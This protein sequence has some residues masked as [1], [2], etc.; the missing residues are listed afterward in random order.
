MERGREHPY[1]PGHTIV[2]P[3]ALQEFV[4]ARLGAVFA[5][6][7][8]QVSRIIDGGSV[9]LVE[10]RYVG[11]TEAGDELDA[12]FAHVWEFG[13]THCIRFQQYSDTWQWRNVLGVAD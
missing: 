9:V 6:F 11:S 12:A 5:P 3:A 2:G 1:H 10:G 8:L 7:D 13:D 4:F